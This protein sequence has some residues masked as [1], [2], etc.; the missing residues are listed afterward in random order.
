MARV[1]RTHRT[2]LALAIDGHGVGAD[3]LAPERPVK[4]LTQPVGLSQ[5]R[6]GL[7]MSAKASQQRRHRP[8]RPVAVGLHF[9]QGDGPLSQASVAVVHRI[10]GILPALVAQS[11]LGGAP[12]P[13][14]TIDAGRLSLLNPGH[15]GIER[16][17][18]GVD[19]GQLAGARQVIGR[20]NHKQRGGIDAAVVA[21]E[22]HLCQGDH[23]AVAG[24][25]QDLARLGVAGTVKPRRLVL[26]QKT[27][28]T[29]GQ[30]RLN[31]E[32]LACRDQP[33]ATEG[34]TEPGHPGVGIQAMVQ[35][36]GKQMNI[37]VRA[38]Q[39]GVEGRVVT[40]D[41]G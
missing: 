32:Q 18:Q 9:T 6:V 34:A 24:L 41:Q 25:V 14:K 33:I 39:P 1:G 31:H 37:A 4:P 3:R 8:V 22:G 2:G 5:Q 38:R 28:H 15:G 13:Q 21:S 27:Q 10:I 30:A 36:A 29:P 23:L 17:Q 7:V 16:R 35:L 19:K 11:S 20:Q 26:R 40:A 12:I